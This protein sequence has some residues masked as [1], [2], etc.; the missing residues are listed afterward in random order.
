MHDQVGVRVADRLADLQEQVQPLVEVE[1]AR[2]AP[3]GDRFALD[4]LQRQVGLV[5]A[6]DAGIEQARDV[7][8]LQPRQDLPFAGEAQA[9][10][11]IGEAGAQQ[12]QRDAALVEPVVAARQPDLAHAA[13]AEHA[14]EP[15]RT[16]AGIGP[17]A[18]HRRDQRLGQEILG[19]VLQHQ[20]FLEIGGELRI[21]HAQCGKPLRA[22]CVVELEHR[23]EQG[24]QPLPAFGVHGGFGSA[25]I[26]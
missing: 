8:M 3:V 5:V 11:R 22:R 18:G 23:I 14:L 19:A 4:V 15:V 24:G 7:R 2:V 12:F 26:V 1:R 13:F 6:A 21:L 25:P 10:V 9:Q 16:D 17:R 20:Q